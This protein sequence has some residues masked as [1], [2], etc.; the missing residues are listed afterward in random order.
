MSISH[1]EA[2]K[3]SKK[4]T[5]TGILIGLILGVIL[6]Y[7]VLN[8]W[9]K[10]SKDAYTESKELYIRQIADLKE[11]RNKLNVDKSIS[12]TNLAICKTEKINLENSIK[13]NYVTKEEFN[14]CIQR[15]S[16]FADINQRITHDNIK[17]S[18]Q[19][20]N[21][22][23]CLQRQ[24]HLQTQLDTIRK[25]LRSKSSMDLVHYKL[26]EQ[27]IYIRQEQEK[28]L[29]DQLNKIDNCQ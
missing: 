12:E 23:S 15:N 21:K 22:A 6:T 24:Q 7:Y 13:Q 3:W 16:Q 8:F 19:V 17:L 1:D 2:S 18:S 11:E 5:F 4:E 10:E 26:T 28:Q 27:D 20:Q 14:R 29:V 25:E 9:N